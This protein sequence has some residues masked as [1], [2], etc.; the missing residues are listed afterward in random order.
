MLLPLLTRF[1]ITSKKLSYFVL[2]NALNNDTTLVELSKSILF[3]P[4][5]KRLRYMGHILN[6][7]AKEYLFSQDC[8]TFKEEYKKAGAPKRR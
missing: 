1:G 6:L 8:A 7:I 5:E 2:N 3:D 4:K